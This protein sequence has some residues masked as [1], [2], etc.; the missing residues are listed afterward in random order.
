MTST[1]QRQAHTLEELAEVRRQLAV[2]RT[3]LR[4]AAI[5]YAATP[6]GAAEMFRRY[7]LAATAEQRNELRDI[8]LAG[9][10]ASTEEYQKRVSLG[11]DTAGD[12]PVEAIPVGDFTD[13]VARALIEQRIMGALRCGPAAVTTGEVVVSLL[14]VMTDG[15]TRKRLKITCAAEFGAFCDP[16]SKVITDALRDPKTANKVRGFVGP[17]VAAAVHTTGQAT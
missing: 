9:L 8:Y 12:G 14:K 13:P 16:L 5:E 6:D 3:R 1:E 17:E 4:T 11:N 15:E 7:E 2:A 10:A